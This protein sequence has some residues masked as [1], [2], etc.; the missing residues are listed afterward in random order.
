MKN[1]SQEHPFCIQTVSMVLFY[2]LLTDMVVFIADAKKAYLQAPLRTK[3]PTRVILPRLCWL[4]GWEKRFRRLAVR[5]QKALYGHPEAGDDWFHHLSQIM[6]KELGFRTV[7]SFPS[8]WWNPVTRVL[9][10]AYVDDVICAGPRTAV[11]EF[12]S[13]LRSRVEVD[14]VTVP[15]RYL[16]RN[17]AISEITE[18]KGLFLPM[19]NYCES[20]V[21]LYLQAVGSKPLKNV[22]TPY[23]TDSEL[24]VNDWEASGTLEEKSASILMKMLWLARLSRPD[25]SHAV[26]RLASGITRWSVNHDKL[27]YRLACYMN[28]TSQY[29]VHCSVKGNSSN[30]SLHLYVD[31]DLGGD[32][33][34]MKSH[35]GMFL[36]IACPKGSYFP[37]SW[38]PRRQ[39]CVSKST[40]ESELVAM[41]EGLYQDALPVQT[42]LE[43]VVGHHIP[44][45]LHKDNQACIHILNS[46]F[47]PKL[48][49]RSLVW[50]FNTRNLPISWQ[51]C[52]LRS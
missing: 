9:T 49:S 18:G 34:T 50:T 25:L 38:S 23:L 3:T 36:M 21:E 19:E 27:L 6:T 15:G 17:H 1:I 16:G 7:E 20:A 35:S 13:K 11:D 10:A 41:N 42:V 52:S 37:I 45:V 33:C 48:K 44:L 14:G 5:L 12:W 2:G 24:N 51:T 43:M 40:T 26:T 30:V 4:P 47:S 28:T 31:A 32:P 29:G 39:Q 8:L 46:G 22:S